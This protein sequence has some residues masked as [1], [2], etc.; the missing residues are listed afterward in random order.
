MDTTITFAATVTAA[1]AQ[2]AVA[3]AALGGPAEISLTILSLSAASGTPRARISFE[4]T[5]DGG[6]TYVPI[7]A[8]TVEGPINTPSP[9]PGTRTISRAC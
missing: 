9:T 7:V 8:L 3:T 4:D 5:A 1:A 2:T 6:T